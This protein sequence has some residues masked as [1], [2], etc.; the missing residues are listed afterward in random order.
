MD[1]QVGFRSERW[2]GSVSPVRSRSSSNRISCDAAVAAAMHSCVRG[3]SQMSLLEFRYFTHCPVH[4]HQQVTCVHRIRTNSDPEH[5][6]KQT[7]K[8]NFSRSDDTWHGYRDYSGA[9]G[10]LFLG[11]ERS[12]SSSLVGIVLNMARLVRVA[13][14]ELENFLQSSYPAVDGQW[15][16]MPS[17]RDLVYT[18]LFILQFYGPFLVMFIV[19]SSMGSLDLSIL[20]A[21]A[22]IFFISICICD[23]VNSSLHTMSNDSPIATFDILASFFLYLNQDPASLQAQYA[24]IALKWM[25]IILVWPFKS[26]SHLSRVQA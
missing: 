1:E 9:S 2:K 17:T 16:L 5:T 24:A 22:R 25:I 7:T 6:N 15:K 14:I 4:R 10:H 23:K 21:E 13:E 11:Q 12:R 20:F 3:K 19:S 26:L 18:G 8:T